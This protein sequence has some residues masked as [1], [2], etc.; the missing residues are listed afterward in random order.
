M[1]DRRG[2]RFRRL[3]WPLTL[4]AIFLLAWI[5]RALYLQRL[6][7]TLLAGD[8]T[9]DA[10]TYWVWSELL[11]RNGFMGKN[12]FFL[13]PLYPYTLALLRLVLGDSIGGVLQIQSLW[14]AAACVLLAD[15][16]RRLTRPAVGLA[17][18]FVIALHP[19]AV[20]FDGLILMESLLFFLESL[21]LWWIVRA[22]AA[23]LRVGAFFVTGLLIALI[24]EGRATA[25]ALLLPAALFLLPWREA[26][27]AALSRAAL[28]LAAGFTLIA[29]PVALR[30]YAVSH[31]WIP[32]TYNFGYNLYAGNSPEASGAFTTITGTQL[33]SPVGPIREDGAIEADGRE[34]LKKAE[35]AKLTPKQSSSY[36][37]GKAWG[38]MRAHPR[39][40]LSLALRKLG[41]MWSR[42]EYPQIENAE[43]FRLAAG[44]L[45]LP[46]LGG[47]S[48]LGALALPGLLFAWRH[49]RAARFVAAYVAVMTLAVVPF[50]VVDRYRHHLVPGVALLVALTLERAWAALAARDRARLLRLALGVLL[51]LAVVWWPSPALSQ[52]KLAWG[53]AFDLG[54][55]WLARGEPA[56]AAEQFERAARME[57]R[58][59]GGAARRVGS[60]EAVERADLYYNYELALSA[61]GRDAEALEW[62]ER[63]VAVAPDRAVALRG[64]ADTYLKL[65]RAAKADSIY[66]VLTG[67][68]GGEGLAD[69]GRG[70]AAAQGGR[71]AEAEAW[72]ANAVAA[73]PNLDAAWGGLIRAQL[74]LGRR[75]AAESTLVRARAAGLALPVLRA[76]EALLEAL[77]GRRAEAERALADI[78]SSA[79]EADASLADVVS[80]TR[81][82]LGARP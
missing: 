22:G 76:H 74:Q 81:H 24:A 63:A 75:A 23:S 4:A 19:M 72:F 27:R 82:L 34:Y 8:L 28:A 33:F 21:L 60:T 43:E 55:R 11:I 2:G 80:V 15:A 9:E 12:P 58:G 64:L 69:A 70:I 7:H 35:G 47:F 52:R 54:T 48:I 62:Y 41:M 57:L 1:P 49:G 17:I 38:W 40:A 5:W 42:R 71:L 10:R 44:P 32:F 31:E 14:G 73:D 66:A 26:H 3:G 29:L 61:L 18:G 65:G 13:G 25:A 79:L 67:K 45:G 56:R 50:F 37:A 20:F 39:R 46:W 36:W 16:A 53:L 6:S 59:R 77:A 51:G 68:V 30:T 78:P